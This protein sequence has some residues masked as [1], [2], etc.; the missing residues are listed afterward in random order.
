MNNKLICIDSDIFALL[1]AANRL[2]RVIELLDFQVSEAR[3]L[4]PIEYMLKN[5]KKFNQ[6]S[7][8]QKQAIL[9]VVSRIKPLEDAPKDA[10]LLQRLSG[11]VDIDFGE[12]VL[13]AT[14]V[15]QPMMWLTTG[16][17][18]AMRA[19]N[20]YPDL[21]DIKNVISSRIVCL[22]AA[23]YLLIREDGYRQTA[24]A[25]SSIRKQHQ[26]LKCILPEK[27]P[28]EAN[29]LDGVKSN[30]RMLCKELGRGFLYCPGCP[31]FREG[32]CDLEEQPA[33]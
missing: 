24:D 25:F 5:K 23:I 6:F 19:L 7:V 22:E 11:R 33:V 28:K 27:D 18:K 9:S 8:E 10:E 1:A 29:K 31:S 26:T 20:S 17:I 32:V 4:P 21:Q 12:Q 13:F 16:D 3:R 14:L 2:D 15:E 30:L